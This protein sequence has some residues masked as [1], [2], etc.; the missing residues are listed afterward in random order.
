[1]KHT[2]DTPLVHKNTR[3]AFGQLPKE[4][5]DDMLKA[6]VAIRKQDTPKEKWEDLLSRRLKG[7]GLG[8][9]GSQAEWIFDFVRHELAQAKADGAREVIGRQPMKYNKSTLVTNQFIASCKNGERPIFESMDYVAISRKQ[10]DEIKKRLATL[11]E[12]YK[13]KV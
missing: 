11:R 10:W 9:S 1:M 4:L 5:Q 8:M 7:M 13:E 6:V 2:K 3:K 12:D